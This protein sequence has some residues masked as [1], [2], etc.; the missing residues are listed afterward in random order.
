MGNLDAAGELVNPVMLDGFTFAAV[1]NEIS[2]FLEICFTQS[3]LP[4]C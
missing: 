2:V 3:Q 4:D 1:G